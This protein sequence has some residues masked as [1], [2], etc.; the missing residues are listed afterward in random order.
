MRKN[1]RLTTEAWCY[2]IMVQVKP[3]NYILEVET[4][5][6]SHLFLISFQVFDLTHYSFTNKIKTRIIISM[7]LFLILGII[8]LWEL[9]E[10]SENIN[11]NSLSSLLSYHQLIFYQYRH[12]FWRNMVL[13]FSTYIHFRHY[14]L[15]ISSWDMTHPAGEAMWNCG[16]VFQTTAMQQ[17]VCLKTVHFCSWNRVGAVT[18]WKCQ[19]VECRHR[20]WSE[21][22]QIAL[23]KS[24]ER[25][26][27]LFLVHLCCDLYVRCW[28]SRWC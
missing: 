18:Q 20:L 2:S 8:V 11:R 28:I 3:C 23:W 14:V 5:R 17:G 6:L 10:L 22:E 9:L 4:K 26:S 24:L 15:N 13:H 21:E 16:R 12:Y 27:S 1:S 7:S 25:P 19:L